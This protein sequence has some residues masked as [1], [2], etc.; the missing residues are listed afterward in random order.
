MTDTMLI[1]LPDEIIR[2]IC[3]LVDWKDAISLQATCRRLRDVAGEQLLWK[4]YCQSSVRYWDPSHQISLK[5][6][7]PSFQQWKQLFQKHQEADV[8]TRNT[9]EEIISG[10]G[11]R[12]PKIQGIVA[13]GYD[14]KNALLMS[15]ARA[16]EFDDHLARRYIIPCPSLA[17]L[18]ARLIFGIDIGRMWRWAACTDPW[19]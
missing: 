3:F 19:R 9:L 15:H 12:T 18:E 7:D 14:S 8:K 17:P 10:Q 11:A 1:Q 6:A 5:L 4:F 13:L 16:S 2:S